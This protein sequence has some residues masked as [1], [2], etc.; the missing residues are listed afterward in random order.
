M[1]QRHIFIDEGVQAFLDHP[2]RHLGHPRQIDI[3]LQQGFLV[4]NNRLFCNVGGHIADPLQMPVDLDRR[5]DE[6]QVPGR[7]LPQGQK[8]D[9]FFLYLRIQP[10]NQ[11][12]IGDDLPRQLRV[13]V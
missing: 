1:G 3:G 6:P 7:G 12:V 13:P 8:A 2:L 5:G 10:V 4:Q 9:A 11:V